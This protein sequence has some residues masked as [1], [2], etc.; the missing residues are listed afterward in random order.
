VVEGYDIEG[1]EDSVLSGR[2]LGEI[3]EDSRFERVD[4]PPA[5]GGK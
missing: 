4:K 5:G 3:A 1:I 2:T